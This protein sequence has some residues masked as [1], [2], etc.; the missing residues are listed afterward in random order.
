[1]RVF[2]DANTYIKLFEG[3]PSKKYFESLEQL[4]LEK[5]IKLIFPR[6]TQNEVYKHV[7]DILKSEKTIEEL[8]FPTYDF[9]DEKLN[10]KFKQHEARWRKDYEEI[11]KKNTKIKKEMVK[12]LFTSLK[13]MT[14]DFDDSSE[15][16]KKASERKAKRMP[17]GKPND[18]LGDQLAWEIILENCTGDDL[19][20]VS[21]DGDWKDLTDLESNNINPFLLEEWN[22]KATKKLELL[23]DMGSLI[24]RFNKRY[25]K[26]KEE[27]EK[28]EKAV[29]SQ[30][31]WYAASPSPSMSYVSPVNITP[32]FSPSALPTVSGVAPSFPLGTTIAPRISL[33]FF[34]PK[35]NCYSCSRSFDSGGYIINNKIVCDDCVDFNI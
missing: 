11:M 19:I 20:V 4:L 24:F 28:E 1:M 9:K 10:K 32:S 22:K 14:F 33:G 34:H 13:K 35:L 25:I 31:P 8:K 3:V 5:K 26:P 30:F 16:F 7:S 23:L 2:I 6:I 12:K 18:P 29:K 17:P 15:L 21:S 27:V